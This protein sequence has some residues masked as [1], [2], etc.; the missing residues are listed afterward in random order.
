MSVNPGHADFPSLLA[1]ALD[2]L[3]ELNHDPKKAA[4][5]L[6]CS[7]SQLI[8]LLKEEPK[9]LAQVNDE[10]RRLGLHALQ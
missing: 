2:V 8:K 1:E 4:G 5:Q 9:A 3:A 6:G 7:P 10:R